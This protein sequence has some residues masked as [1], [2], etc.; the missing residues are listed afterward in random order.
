M[1]DDE[2]LGGYVDTHKC[3]PA[4]LG[5]D[6]VSYSAEV[7][8]DE[9]VQEDGRYGAALLFIRWSGSGSQAE[10]HLETDYVAHGATPEIAQAVVERL[11][12]FQL[13]EHLDRLVEEA[14]GRPD[15]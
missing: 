9:K 13:K 12:L 4:F 14:K 15:W 1:R 11:T 10:G 8:V 6:G 7:Y 2:T 3:P 5:S